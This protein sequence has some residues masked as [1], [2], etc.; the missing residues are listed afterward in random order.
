MTVKLNQYSVDN[1]HT[2]EYKLEIENWKMKKIA[3]SE[4][5]ER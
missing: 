3:V 5:D 4:T 1:A 2:P